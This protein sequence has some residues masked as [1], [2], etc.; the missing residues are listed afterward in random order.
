VFH[1]EHAAP[2]QRLQSVHQYP[3]SPSAFPRICAPR[4]RTR[5][6]ALPQP[7]KPSPPSLVRPITYTQ[8]IQLRIAVQVFEDIGAKAEQT[9]PGFQNPLEIFNIHWYAG[10]NSLR[11]YGEKLHEMMYPAPIEIANEGAE[12]SAL[13]YLEA[14]GRRQRACDPHG[15]VPR[16]IRPPVDPGRACSCLR[17]RTRS[18]SWARPTSVGRA[19]RPSPTPST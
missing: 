1:V 3:V 9:D 2:G 5:T 12:Y 17:D 14:V 11:A 16:R 19:G 13:E 15:K 7:P 8:C 18:A 10:A 6:R 4:P